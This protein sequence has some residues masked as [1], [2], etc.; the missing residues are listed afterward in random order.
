MIGDAFVGKVL[1]K[2]GSPDFTSGL[3]ET[4]IFSPLM[5]SH[6]FVKSHNFKEQSREAEVNIVPSL[7]KQILMMDDV[8]PVNAAIRCPCAKSHNNTRLSA[9]PDARN[10]PQFEKHKVLIW[11]LC[12]VMRRQ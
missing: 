5:S 4:L 3:W 8:C 7:L 10:L 11:A 1:N 12:P 2:Y 6:N 9:E